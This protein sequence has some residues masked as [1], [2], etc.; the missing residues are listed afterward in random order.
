MDVERES[1]VK[2]Y[3]DKGHLGWRS[4]NEGREKD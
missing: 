3:R 4:E 2:Q 1:Y